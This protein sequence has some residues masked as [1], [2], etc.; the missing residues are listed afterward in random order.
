MSLCRKCGGLRAVKVE[1][2]GVKECVPC[3]CVRCMECMDSGYVKVS[4]AVKRCECR[5]TSRPSRNLEVANI[6]QLYRNM[7]L[8]S[9]HTDFASCSQS[10]KMAHLASKAFAS[11]P[12]S[13]AGTGVILTGTIGSGK[14]HLAVGIL[15]SFITMGLTGYF[16]SHEA[17]FGELRESYSN[18]ELEEWKILRRVA[19]CD[20]LVLDDLGTQP[21]TGTGALEERLV[22][23]LTGRYDNNRVTIIT[24]NLPV[25]QSLMGSDIDESKM[26]E[27]ERDI[28]RAM[29]RQTLGDKLGD[30]VLSRLMQMCMVVKVAGPDMRSTILKARF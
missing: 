4:D 27:A 11:H 17:L 8:D 18:P 5:L 6:P 13:G 7:D 10:Q 21:V 3:E 29:R 30:R 9:Y 14:T 26:N 1:R 12:P 23:I 24:T 22:T 25:E 28:K 16:T 20:V 2:G 19:E 15:K